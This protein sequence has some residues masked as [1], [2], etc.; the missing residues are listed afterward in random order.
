MCKVIETDAVQDRC[1]GA[2]DQGGDEPAYGKY[3]QGTDD[4][5]NRGQ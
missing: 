4:G 3:Y 1:Y 2:R 5:G